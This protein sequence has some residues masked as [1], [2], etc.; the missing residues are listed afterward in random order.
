MPT[1]ASNKNKHFTPKLIEEIEKTNHGI[2]INEWKIDIIIYADDVVLV[3]N[4][5]KDMEQLLKIT[6]DFGKRNET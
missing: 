5:R 4:S 1:N 6:E 3:A 2:Q